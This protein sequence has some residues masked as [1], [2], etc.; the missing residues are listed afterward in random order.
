MSK[1]FDSFRAKKSFNKLFKKLLSLVLVRNIW[2]ALVML[3]SDPVETNS[4]LEPLDP[5][6]ITIIVSKAAMVET[7]PEIRIILSVF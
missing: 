6:L 7:A 3:G 2:P 5:I 1:T 4:L